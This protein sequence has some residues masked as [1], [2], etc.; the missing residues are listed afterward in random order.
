MRKKI[1]AS[2]LT[3][4][5]FAHQTV[6]F[7]DV[8]VSNSGNTYVGTIKSM[9]DKAVEIETKDGS[10]QFLKSEVKQI[11]VGENEINPQNQP[12]KKKVE[13]TEFEVPSGLN[14]PF[15]FRNE[16]RSNELEEGNIVPIMV[17]DDVFVKDIL[18][19]TKGT[20]G[21]ATIGEVKKSKSWGRGGK[22]NLSNIKIKDKFGNEHLLSPTINK[23]GDASNVM[24]KAVPI[25]GAVVLSPL[26]LFFGFKKGK[27]VMIKPEAVFNAYVISNKTIKITS[28]N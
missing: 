23:E 11:K 6:A 2:I 24:G 7:A 10:F 3:I 17:H 18:V 4:L 21:M 19:F 5:F 14:V 22:L 8:V 26:F 27:Q 1:I 16:L 13:L 28:N 12:E 9:S 25:A 20:E 15:N